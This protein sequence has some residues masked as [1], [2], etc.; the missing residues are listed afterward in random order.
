ERPAAVPALRGRG[1]GPAGRRGAPPHRAGRRRPD[2]GA[3][4]RGG[5]R[6]VAGCLA[7][8]PAQPAGAARAG[9]GVAHALPGRGRPVP[10]RIGGVV[11]GLVHAPQQLQGRGDRAAQP[12]EKPEL[13]R[14]EDQGRGGRPLPGQG[15]RTARRRHATPRRA[16]VRPPDRHALHALHRHLGRAAVQA[17]LA[18]GQGR[19]AAEGD[20]GR[21]HH[22]RQ[23]LGCQNAAVRPLLRQRH[24]R[25]RGGAGCMQHR[26][27]IP[28]ALCVRADAAAPAPGLDPAQGRGEQRAT[29]AAGT[30]LRQRRRLSHG[31]LRR[32][33]RRARR[34]GRGDPVPRWRRAA[35]NAA[36]RNARRDAG[37][38][39]LRRAHRDGGRRRQ[40]AA[41]PRAGRWRG[42]AGLL[43]PAGGALEEAL[44]RVD[45]LG[46]H[47]RPQAAF[48]HAAE[49]IPP[50]SDV[51]RPDRM[52]PVPLRHGRGLGP[53]SRCS[54]WC[55]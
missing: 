14:I 19:G 34:S 7:A 46:A 38:S 27:R 37:Q 3:R 9:A 15:R 6:R 47:A 29:L 28:A 55:L 22:R 32:P 54:T 41:R 16:R 26:A 25:H 20:A 30:G 40:G 10:G 8:E 49:G 24:H 44:R 35:A 21:G 1:R 33:Q 45:R 31:R 36:F 48:A 50:R 42:R 51:E 39:S 43:H 2:G 5:A 4:R 18:R 12:A 52:P 17:R 23:R 13:R 53:Q 11:G